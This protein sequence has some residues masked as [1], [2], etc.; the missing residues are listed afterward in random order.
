VSLRRLIK[1]AEHVKI[2]VNAEV[3]GVLERIEPA[4]HFVDGFCRPIDV[5]LGKNPLQL[6]AVSQRMIRTF[7]K[8]IEHHGT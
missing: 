4:A 7:R 8:E 3:L 1:L 2:L 5:Q 6:L